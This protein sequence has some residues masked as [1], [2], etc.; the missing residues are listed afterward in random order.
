[1]MRTGPDAAAGVTVTGRISAVRKCVAGRHRVHFPVCERAGRVRVLAVAR[2]LT[3]AGA[4]GTA[5][6]LAEDREG[7]SI[8][9]DGTAH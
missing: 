5:G 9:M 3:K 1:M 4:P 2:E 8:D 7:G 6:S